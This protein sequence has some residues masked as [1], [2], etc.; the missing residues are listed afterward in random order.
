VQVPGRQCVTQE[1]AAVA[2]RIRLLGIFGVDIDDQP[3]P[4]SMWTR[5]DV[6]ALVKALALSPARRLHREQ[7]V[8]MLWPDL[9]PQE[10]A[11]RLH[12]ATH[13]ARRAIGLPD[14]IVLRGGMILL[15]P[16]QPVT[17]DLVEFEAAAESA[18]AERGRGSAVNVLDRYEAEAL[19]GDLYSEWADI[20]R[21]RVAALRRRL[22]RQAQRWTAVVELDPLDEEARV[23]LMHERARS[24]DLHGALREYE[25]WERLLQRE[26][27]D[28]PGAD[29]RSLRDELAERLRLGGALSIADEGRL[30]QQIRFCK[31]SDDVTLAYAMSGHGPPLVKVANWLTHIDYDWQSSVW[32]H[33]LVEL[34]RRSRLVRYDERGCGLSD[35]DIPRQSFGSWVTDLETVVDASG[36]DRF[37]LLAISQ[38]AAV[39]VEYVARHP[40]RVTKLLI[41]GGYAQGRTVRQTT[42][43]GRQLE[44]VQIELARLGWGTDAPAFRQVF[45]SQFMPDGSRELWDEFNELQRRTTSA[46]NA[47]KVLRITGGI[48]VRKAARQIQVPTLVL[49]A[50]HDQRPPYEQG[51]LLASLIENSRFVTL[52]S[53]NHILLAD[54]P[55]WPIF[56]AEMDAFLAEDASDGR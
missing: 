28:K 8:D 50:R 32:R 10:A 19:P 6:A 4:E 29:A 37:P 3:V 25:R 13:F 1:G 24:G 46:E 30:E 2:V 34:S 18:L 17:V 33:W 43:E 42:E 53:N 49:H 36:L 41:Y 40:E 48:D 45:T 11:P 21:E 47:A 35:R 44:A 38:G 9:S 20:T 22:L 14:A 31:T 39:A 52:Q 16:D 26:L 5:R 55:A 15:L 51:R 7:V 54:E 12:K 23:G 27:G 56:L